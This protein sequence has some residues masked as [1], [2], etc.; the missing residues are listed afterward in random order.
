MCFS[1]VHQFPAAPE[2]VQTYPLA[3]RTGAQGAKR[4]RY[5]R[6]PSASPASFAWATRAAAAER[7]LARV[8]RLRSAERFSNGNDETERSCLGF[9]E[10]V[11]ATV[12]DAA[13]R[14]PSA[15]S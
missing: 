3:R 7:P 4:L 10:A 14:S 11:E 15:L 1:S 12:P 13:R 2:N 9:C 6:A 5:E 8:S